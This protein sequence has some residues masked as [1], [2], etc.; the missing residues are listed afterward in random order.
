MSCLRTCTGF[1][2]K[3]AEA[4]PL[5]LKHS[6]F[7]PGHHRQEEAHKSV[8]TVLPTLRRRSE[9]IVTS[10]HIRANH[11]PNGPATPRRPPT[12]SRGLQESSFLFIA[13]IWLLF[14]EAR[15]HPRALSSRRAARNY[16]NNMS[17][18]RMPL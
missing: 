6:H 10:P 1:W 8:P 16:S 12:A 13:A 17:K 7:T 9:G 18:Y 3:P 11:V 14:A 5:R 4:P 2:E 15:A